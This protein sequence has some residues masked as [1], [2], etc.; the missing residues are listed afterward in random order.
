ML[1][2]ACVCACRVGG[3]LSAKQV[4]MSANWRAILPFLDPDTAFPDY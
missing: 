4:L 3:N 1:P 2:S